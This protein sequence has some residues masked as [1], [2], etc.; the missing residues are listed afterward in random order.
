MSKTV[1]SCVLSGMLIVLMPAAGLAADEAST[2][3]IDKIDRVDH[4]DRVEQWQ[5]GSAP[6]FSSGKYGT[7]TRT[8]ILQTPF[9]FRRLFSRGD[10]TAV[11]PFTCLWG[12]G[13]VTLVNGVPVRPERLANVTTRTGLTVTTTTVTTRTCGMGDIV[14]RGR[15]YMIDE[16]GWLPTVAVRAH[17]KAPTAKVEQGLGS[18]EPDEGAGLEVS[19]TFITRTTAMVDGGYTVIGKPAG[20]TYNDNWWY[21]LGI[22]QDV[23]T[24]SKPIVNLS[25]MYEE[26]RAVVPGLENARDVLGTVSLRGASGWRIQLSGAVGLSSGAPDHAFMLGASRRF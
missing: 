1:L 15:Y 11:F 3:N 8:E 24:G 16:H 23:G 6:S 7:D 14:V 26:Y 5:V 4:V 9:T 21:D 13:N 22:A 17:V 20:V 2:G 10:V 25:V 19:R 18:G 12:S